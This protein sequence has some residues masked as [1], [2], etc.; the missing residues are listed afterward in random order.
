MF[1]SF[2]KAG[3]E[4]SPLQTMGDNSACSRETKVRGTTR[5]NRQEVHNKEQPG[6]RKAGKNFP[7]RTTQRLWAPS[8]WDPGSA[9]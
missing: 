4:G 1:C 3:R 2:E 6:S 7:N 9:K 8:N 5:R